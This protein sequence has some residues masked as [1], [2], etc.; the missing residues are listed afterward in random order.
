MA[1]EK[2]LIEERVKAGESSSEVNGK[3]NHSFLLYYSFLS[4]LSL[5]PQFSLSTKPSLSLSLS[6][7]LLQTQFRFVFRFPSSLSFLPFSS[8]LLFT[9]FSLTV[10]IFSTS[11]TSSK[12]T[13]FFVLHS[14]L[15]NR[16]TIGTVFVFLIVFILMSLLLCFSSIGVSY[17]FD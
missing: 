13:F 17:C 6:L 8:F 11:Q 1:G 15:W 10:L 5:S 12:T 16:T 9:C 3:W 14:Q 7:S 2:H 4:S